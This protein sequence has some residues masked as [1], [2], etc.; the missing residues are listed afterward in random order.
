MTAKEIPARGMFHR[1]HN[2]SFGAERPGTSVEDT[3]VIG[4]RRTR[5]TAV[6]RAVRTTWLEMMIEHHTGAVEMAETQVDGGQYQPAIGLAKDII[7]SQNAEIQIMEG[8]LP[9]T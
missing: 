7:A 8:L 1:R 3:T 5:R 9:R 2:C 4:M 6:P